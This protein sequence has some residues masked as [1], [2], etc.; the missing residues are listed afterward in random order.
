MVVTGPQ[1]QAEKFDAAFEY[2]PPETFDFNGRWEDDHDP[3]LQV[4]IA[5]NV[6]TGFT[7]GGTDTTLLTPLLVRLGAF[8]LINDRG[9]E[10]ISGRILT[11]GIAVGAIETTACRQRTWRA[12][13]K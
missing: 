6:V 13:K 7:C 4:F 12:L 8:S 3:G 5:G 10:V 11:D 1:G 9:V 2:A